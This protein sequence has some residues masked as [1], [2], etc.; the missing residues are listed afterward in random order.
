MDNTNKRL[1]SGVGVDITT[2]QSRSIKNDEITINVNNITED[3]KEKIIDEII[4]NL[5]GLK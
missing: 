5:N 2:P 4:K 3:A 1:L